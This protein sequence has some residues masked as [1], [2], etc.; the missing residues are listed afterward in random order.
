M[1]AD[2]LTPAQR[3]KI[4]R[5]ARQAALSS[6]GVVYLPSLLAGNST[7][8]FLC[9]GFDRTPILFDGRHGYYPAEWIAREFPEAA[10][11]AENVAR[12]VRECF[13]ADEAGRESD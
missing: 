2:H 1:P 7:E 3:K 5:W 11:A 12:R 9:A 8:V 4:P 10:K 6:D 13:Q